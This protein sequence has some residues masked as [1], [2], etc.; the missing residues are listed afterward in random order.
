MASVWITGAKGFIGRHLALHLSRSGHTVYGI[1][2]GLWPAFES[3]AWGLAGWINGDI[4]PSNL[5][6]LR[7]D[8]GVPSRVFHVAGGS[9]VSSSIA[10]P[11]EDFSRTVSTSARLLEWL[12][13]G[14]PDT[15]LVAVSSAAVYGAQYD[16]PIGEDFATRPFSPYGHHK[17]MMEQL[18]H[19]YTEAFG[20]RCTI[21]RLFSVYGPWLRKQLLWDLCSRLAGGAHTLQLGGSGRELRDWI[22]ISDVVRLL[23]LGSLLESDNVVLLNGGSGIATPVSSVAASVVEAWGTP[24]QIEFAGVE[25][26]GDPFSLVA[27]PGALAD[28][29]F[30]WQISLAEGIASYVRWFKQSRRS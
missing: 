9:S 20:L 1:G 28:R 5:Q 15:R 24:A 21:V 22:E 29:G 18:C 8:G 6:A 13:I 17:L 19:S 26:P 11:L 30:A 16:G 12:R 14:A 4:D 27:R 23:D 10:N 25:R 3:S 2:H 7:R